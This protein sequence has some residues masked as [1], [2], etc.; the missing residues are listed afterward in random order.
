MVNKAVKKGG[1]WSIKIDFNNGAGGS[2]FEH[3]LE[4]E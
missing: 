1:K 2:N 4:Q 3:A